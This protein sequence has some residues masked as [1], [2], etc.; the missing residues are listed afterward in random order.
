MEETK[1]VKNWMWLQLAPLAS[2]GSCQVRDLRRNKWW[3]I[4]RVYCQL[5]H[6]LPH[7]LLGRDCGWCR[8]GGVLQSVRYLYYCIG[9]MR[10]VGPG[11]LVP[12]NPNPNPNPSLTLTLT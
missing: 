9:C 3:A 2:R 12:P 5:P 10:G 8:E 6:S 1:K 4:V 7:P 11:T